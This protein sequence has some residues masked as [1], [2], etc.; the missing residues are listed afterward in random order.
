MTD[1]KQV[2]KGGLRTL[3]FSRITESLRTS[4]R[5]LLTDPLTLLPNSLA[6]QLSIPTTTSVPGAVLAASTKSQPASTGKTGSGGKGRLMTPEE[7]KRIVEALTRA[8]TAEEVR[9]L[10][11]MLAEGLVPEGG[12]EAAAAS[13]EV[14]Q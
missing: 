9:K 2:A 4:S 10:E 13:A 14:A 12:V 5:A 1:L 7:K 11:R 3:D 8:G 6:N